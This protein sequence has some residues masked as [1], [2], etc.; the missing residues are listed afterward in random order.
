MKFWFSK[1]QLKR[2]CFKGKQ[3]HSATLHTSYLSIMITVLCL[4]TLF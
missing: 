4:A 1:S 3:F 2:K